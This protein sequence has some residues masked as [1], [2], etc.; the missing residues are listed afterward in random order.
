MLG[1]VEVKDATAIVREHDENVEHAEG[2]R[3]QARGFS[4]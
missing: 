4:L 3:R 2:R 1:H